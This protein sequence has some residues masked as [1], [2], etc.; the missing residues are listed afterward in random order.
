M[1][2]ILFRHRMYWQTMLKEC[3]EF[4]KGFQEC[5]KHAG[6]QHVPASVLHS[7]VKPWPFRGYE[8]DLIY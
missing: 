5:Q 3:I 2:W 4:T 7:I 1:K 8:L 6:I